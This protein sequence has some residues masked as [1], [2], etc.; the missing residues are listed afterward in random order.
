MWLAQARIQGRVALG[1][2]FGCRLPVEGAHLVGP[3]AMHVA[4][5]LY[6]HRQA[7]VQVLRLEQL[8]L[9]MELLRHASTGQG[10]TVLRNDTLSL[11]PAGFTERRALRPPCASS[12]R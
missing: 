11:G 4:L 7:P 2:A 12:G 1:A 10:G 8:L 9:A 3:Q 5:A 6:R